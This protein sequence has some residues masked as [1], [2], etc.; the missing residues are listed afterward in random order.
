MSASTFVFGDAIRR[1]GVALRVQIDDED[2]FAECRHTGAQVDGGGGFANAALLVC[3]CDDFCHAVPPLFLRFFGGFGAACI[4]Y[5]T[6]R[7]KLKKGFFQTKKV[8]Q[9]FH[10]E[11]LAGGYAMP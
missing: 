2:L 10:V 1:C 3:Y 6:N 7:R 9:M 5:S 11:H 4:Y 8:R